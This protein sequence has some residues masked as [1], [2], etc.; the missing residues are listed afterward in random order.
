MMAW[1]WGLKLAPKCTEGLNRQDTAGPNVFAIKQRLEGPA[2]GLVSG[3]GKET[4]QS[5]FALEQAADGLGDGKGPSEH[6]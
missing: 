6:G 2:D 1:Q 4:E 5:P 3:A